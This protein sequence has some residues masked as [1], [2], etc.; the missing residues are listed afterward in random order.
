MEKRFIPIKGFSTR[1]DKSDNM[2]L[3]GFFARYDDVYEIDKGATES[4]APGAF[5]DCLNGDIRAL[6]NHDSNIVLG[7]TR[8]GTFFLEDRKDGLWGRILINPNDRT[9]ADVYN[10]VARRDLSGCSFGFG[11]EKERT[12]VRPDGSI[13]FTIEKVNP[14]IE[15]SICTFPAYERTNIQAR[16]K[17]IKAIRAKQSEI[18]A[19]RRR[20]MDRLRRAGKGA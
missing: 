6:Y 4:I 18:L 9:A 12:E 17:D 15:C 10:R 1:S 13:H 3:E 11:I 2:I 7:R 5:A 19:W 8:S 16:S 14:L 20:M